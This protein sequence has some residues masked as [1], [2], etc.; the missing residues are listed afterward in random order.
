[1]A[2]NQRDIVEVQFPLP[3]GKVQHH[4]VVV[5]S[6]NDINEYEDAFVGV[7][8]SS[9][10]YD[11]PFTFKFTETM[12]T[13]KPRSKY[14]ARSHLIQ[15]FDESDVTRKRL[16]SVKIDAFNRLIDHIYNSVLMIPEQ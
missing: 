9:Q 2:V 5:V 14:Q 10:D 8:L 1:V 13:Q 4:P 15:L 11:D 7:M 12:L 3:G 6:N 16:G